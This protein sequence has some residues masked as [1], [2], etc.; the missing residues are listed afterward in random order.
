MRAFKISASAILMICL[1]SFASCAFAAQASLV[2]G[3][4]QKGNV[5]T[6]NK[7]GM[8][9]AALDEMF[10]A[11]GIEHKPANGGIAAEIA[12]KKIEFWDGSAAVRINMFM[13]PLPATVFQQDGHWWCEASSAV[14]SFNTFLTSAGR[15]AGVKLGITSAPKTQER[16]TQRPVASDPAPAEKQIVKETPPAPPA[17]SLP[18]KTEAPRKSGGSIGIL[19]RVRWGEQENAYRAVV[20]LSHKVD[21]EITRSDTELKVVFPDTMSPSTSGTS[22][23][24]PL[25]VV[26]RQSSNSAVVAFTHAAKEIRWFWLED[27]YR[28][29]VDFYTESKAAPVPQIT[30]PVEKEP[31]RPEIQQT[32]PSA[33]RKGN[34]TKKR[35]LVVVDAGHGGHD[36]G[37]IGNNLREK[38]INLKAAIELESYLK[39]RGMDVLLTRRTDV[40]LK[41]AERTAFAN[42]R[43][44]DVFI[45]LHCNALP[46]GKHAKGVEL[47][48]MADST[49]K[50][51]L[52]LAILEN[53]ELSGNAQTAAEIDAAAD[54]RTK[55]LLQILGDMQQNDK[56]TESTTLAEHLYNRMRSSGMSIRNVRQAPFFVLRG[57]GMPAL[58]VEMGY[59]T[60]KSDAQQLNSQAYRKKLLESTAQGIAKYVGL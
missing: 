53:R 21:A 3:G 6:L 47:Y 60:E 14:N 48:L 24:P 5:S 45:S 30:A 17:V 27:P 12:G 9:Y 57:A 36:P 16:A 29:V 39:A 50:D 41:L 25:A 11:A 2:V 22:P 46:K 28:F 18:E 4:E 51:A 33:P 32:V 13:S 10:R 43:D 8:D 23:W 15:S 19:S 42:E 40:Y 35:P 34:G 20:E 37:A 58:L 52:N 44:A 56:I 55:L 59:I 54:K 1:I 7:D 38:D 49:D 31:S 26:S